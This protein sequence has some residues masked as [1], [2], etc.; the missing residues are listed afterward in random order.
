MQWLLLLNHANNLESIVLCHRFTQRCVSFSRFGN[1]VSFGLDDVLLTAASDS[2][3]F[4]PVLADALPPRGQEALPSTAYSEHMDVLSRT[5][6]KLSLDW[7]DELRESQSSKLD[8]RFLS[9][10]NSRSERRKLPFFSDLHHEIF[11]SSR[12]QRYRSPS[13]SFSWPQNERQEE[14]SLLLSANCVFGG[15]LGF[16][17]DAGQSGSSLDFQ[18]CRMS[19]PLQ[20]KPSCLSEYLPQV[21]RPHGS[22]RP[23]TASRV[24][25][26][27]AVPLVDES[28]ETT[29]HST[30][31]SPNQ[32][33]AQLLSCPLKMARLHFSPEWD[34]MGAI[35]HHHMITTDASM[36]GWGAV[37]EG[38]PAR[39]VWTGEF[40]SW[41]MNCLELRAVF[42]ALMHLFPVFGKHHII[43]R[44]DNMAVVSH[45]NRQGGSRSRTLDRLARRL[46]L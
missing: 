36:T 35:H 37:F 11:R 24:A 27:E 5:T 21:T 15:S 1:A 20:A 40:L 31:Y 4:G 19:G 44:T 29:L 23:C 12:S 9:S 28:A 25:P 13:H 34:R 2:E 17:S 8:E 22:S 26:H 45:I 7:P 30:S 18:F 6:E 46:L 38:R 43:V 14:C 16:R 41:H 3:D 33:V 39:G 42:L 32:C 10:P